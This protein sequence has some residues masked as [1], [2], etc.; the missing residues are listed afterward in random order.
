LPSVPGLLHCAKYLFVEAM[1][2]IAPKSPGPAEI[3]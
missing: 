1:V 3:D 2:T